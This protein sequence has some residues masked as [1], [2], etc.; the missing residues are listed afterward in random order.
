MEGNEDNG[1]D[2]E[3]LEDE[4]E[5]C[6][7]GCEEPTKSFSWAAAALAVNPRLKSIPFTRDT[8]T[9]QEDSN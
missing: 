6:E 9:R 5:R 7:G 1:D 8:D 3:G 4:L 2:E